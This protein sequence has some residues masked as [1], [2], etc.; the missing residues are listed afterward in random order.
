MGGKFQ[1]FQIKRLKIDEF[2]SSNEMI[3]TCKIWKCKVCK[4]T[5]QLSTHT[6]TIPVVPGYSPLG[7]PY[8]SALKETTLHCFND[9]LM[10]DFVHSCLSHQFCYVI[11]IK[12]RRTPEA[13]IK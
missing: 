2:F 5:R 6:A 7:D 8:K 9:F 13:K 3:I 10:F 11:F 4:S 1:S 12:K